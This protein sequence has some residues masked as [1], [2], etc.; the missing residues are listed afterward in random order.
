MEGAADWRE[1]PHF[2]LK[3]ADTG[4]WIAEEAWFAAG[5]DKEPSGVQGTL[6]VHVTQSAWARSAQ[7]QNR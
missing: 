6:S 4:G 5:V 3:L 7:A 2:T 1:D